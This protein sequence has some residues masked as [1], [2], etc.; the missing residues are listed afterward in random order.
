MKQVYISSDGRQFESPEEC[1]AHEEHAPIFAKILEW[2]KVEYAG[3]K[4]LATRNAHAAL[5]WEKARERVLTP[6]DV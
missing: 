4:G 6:M 5:D 1:Q 2:A 3:K